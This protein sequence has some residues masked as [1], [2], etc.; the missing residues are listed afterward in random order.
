MLTHFAPADTY[1][2]RVSIDELRKHTTRSATGKGNR[3]L[4]RFGLGA[5]S[6]LLYGHGDGGG[7]PDKM[8]H[9]RLER[10]DHSTA[11]QRAHLPSVQHATPEEFF[12]AL[13]ARAR[14]RPPQRWCGELYLELHQG[15]FTSQAQI[16]RYNRVAEVLLRTAETFSIIAAC[17]SCS[18]HASAA[19]S[20]FVYP[21]DA[22]SEIWKG[23]LLHQFHD[24][25]PGS[26]IGLV[27]RDTDEFFSEVLGNP[28][29]KEGSLKH[30]IDAAITECV[31]K[32]VSS[33]AHPAKKRKTGTTSNII[34][35]NALPFERE[36][37]IDVCNEGATRTE[38]RLVRVPALGWSSLS[39][40]V[41]QSDVPMRICQCSCDDST[42]EIMLKNAYVTVTLTRVVPCNPSSIAVCS[43]PDNVWRLAKLL[44][45][46][47]CTMTFLS[48]G[49]HGI[50]AL[51]FRS[52]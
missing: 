20:N 13:A 3:D 26:S 28:G 19:I 18:G 51:S 15:T 49:T 44:I 14:E 4:E 32:A 1:N 42:K 33:N 7:G 11:F 16:K 25:I 36:E 6:L 30:L 37:L 43:H 27:Y 24:V 38:L 8:M 21:A 17:M 50:R 31:H 22:L 52:G 39:H 34:L 45:G 5:P 48:F 29:H 35:V 47:S 46:W 12:D 2:A 40:A 23:V 41:V 9:A 10:L